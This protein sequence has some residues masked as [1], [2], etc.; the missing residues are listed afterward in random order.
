[1]PA[2]GDIVFYRGGKDLGSR[3]VR[4]W[5]RGDFSHCGIVTKLTDDGGYDTIEALSPGGVSVVHHACPDYS[6]RAL[7]SA[8][9][10]STGLAT[11]LA[12]LDKQLG[13]PYSY[14]DIVDQPLRAIF[15]HGPLLITPHGYDC[16][17]L[18]AHF[19]LVSDFEAVPGQRAQL[20]DYETISPVE[21]A[22]VL[23]V[24]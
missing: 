3:I 22:R 10:S 14:F 1:M 5:T 13:Q 6:K 16:S 19:L 24:V 20:L 23:Q 7:T 11:A 9:I 18:A 15:R 8:H 2:C 21:L 4:W 12:W 17:D